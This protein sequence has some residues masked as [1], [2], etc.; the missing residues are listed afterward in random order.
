MLKYRGDMENGFISALDCLLLHQCKQPCQRAENHRIVL[1]APG[2]HSEK[3][4]VLAEYFARGIIR[5]A[6]V[7]E[8]CELH[9]DQTPTDS[10]IAGSGRFN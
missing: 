8:G 2:E 10:L 9:G 3:F 7:F 1:P 4:G 5:P 6:V